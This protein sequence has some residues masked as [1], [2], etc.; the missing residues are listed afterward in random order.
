MT[1]GDSKTGDNSEAPALVAAVSSRALFDL[2]EEN[3]IYHEHGA[4]KYAQVQRE[5]M[6]QIAAPGVAFS[7]VKKLLSFNEE[8]GPELVRLIVLSRNDPSTGLR[9]FRSIA[10]HQLK[11]ECGFFTRGEPPFSYSK[12][13]GA[14]LFLSARRED[15]ES[16]LEAK[17]PAAHVVGGKSRGGGD[18]ILRIA[19]DGDSVLFGDESEQ[20]FQ[21]RGI[22]VF[23]KQEEAL[24]NKPLS[25]GPFKPFLE[26]LSQLR[27][28]LG[29]KSDRIR[30][31]LITARGAPAHERPILTLTH[32]GVEV[33]EAFF[34]NGQEK[35]GV[36]AEFGAD[37]FFDD[38]IRHVK[39][40]PQGGHVPFGVSGRSDNSS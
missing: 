32:W 24:K 26:A 21:E 12:R 31:A 40:V 20:V 9:V 7:L 11:I 1:L 5:R 30:I 18:D 22:D 16:A 29:K 2:E 17:V 3:Q 33:D 19:F 39:G 23:R 13:L 27:K 38:Q 4:A 34:L 14:H 37:F 35:Q 28:R 8:G 15:V 6:H 25:P 10:E 36:V